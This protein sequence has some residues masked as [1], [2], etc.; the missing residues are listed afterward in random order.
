MKKIYLPLIITVFLC[1]FAFCA[2]AETVYQDT[3]VTSNDEVSISFEIKDNILTVSGMVDDEECQYL[4]INIDASYVLP[5]S[6]E[7]KFTTRIDLSKIESSRAT[8]GIFLGKNLTDAFKSVFYGDDIVLEKNE[9]K[10]NGAIRDITGK[11]SKV[12][13]LIIPTNEELVIAR[14]TV[15]LL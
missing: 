4:I 13:V 1:I 10:N 8:V 14:E 7:M 15:E 12:K 3:L 6:S 2:V 5:V 11:N 9:E